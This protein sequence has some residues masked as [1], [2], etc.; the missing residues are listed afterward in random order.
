MLQVMSAQDSSSTLK[1]APLDLRPLPRPGKPLDER[2][3]LRA[4]NTVDALQLAL[5]CAAQR[6]TCDAILIADDKGM[7]VAASTTTLE[8]EMLAAVTPIIARGEAL[9]TIRRRGEARELSVQTL[10]VLGE[11]LHVAVLGGSEQARQ[12]ELA[13]SAAAAARI[14]AA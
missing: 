11:T 9:A 10:E 2:R 4:G 14:L 6:A 12:L 13:K 3:Q 7:L 5:D 8:L 1:R